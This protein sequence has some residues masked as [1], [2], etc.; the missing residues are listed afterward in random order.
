MILQAAQKHVLNAMP[1]FVQRYVAR[2]ESSPLGTR[3][4]RGAFWSLAGAFVSRAVNLAGSI[5]VAH[6]LKKHG[7]GEFSIVVGMIAMLGVIGSLGLSQAITKH[8]AE[9]RHVEPARAG[10]VLRL[11]MIVVAATA[12][13]IAALLMLLAPWMARTMLGAEHLATAIRMGTAALVLMAVNGAQIGALAGLEAFKTTA[14]LNL[15]VGLLSAPLTVLGA[16]W[17]GLYGGLIGL[18]AALAVSC[19]LFRIALHREAHKAGIPIRVKGCS[20]E[21]RT[22]LGFGLPT[23]LS[24]LVQWPVTWGCG[25]MLV[26]RPGGFDQQAV[27][28]AALQ[29]R[30]AIL[31]L[32]G[33]V[34]TM[35]LPVLSNLHG[36]NDQRRY[37]KV[38]WYN[39]LLNTGVATVAAAAIAL[40][41]PWIMATYGA[42]FRGT[43]LV[44][45][46]LAVSAVL[47][48]PS[49]V[50]GQALLS[51]GR[52]WVAL[53]LNALWAV[54]LLLLAHAFISRGYG[55]VGLALAMVL[56]VLFLG[57]WQSVF[58][59][60]ESRKAVAVE[61]MPGFPVSSV[62]GTSIAAESDHV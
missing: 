4:A 62:T 60:R 50:M 11:A 61:M 6:I 46:L 58:V 1:S 39:V 26:N 2:V 57:I 22:L 19:T 53:A 27:Y 42:G 51:R 34:V 47:A 55:A 37:R 10:R 24:G 7:F 14:K 54:V 29:W 20:K 30:A 40:L 13:T 25:A 21:W 8:I 5:W 15:I 38:L 41:A 31:F 56:A 33:A 44:L 49:D 43:Q 9:F 18:S 48:S 23:F 3:L 36:A 16:Y 17:G 52:M 32:P 35:I 12:V 59:V 45:I 28:A